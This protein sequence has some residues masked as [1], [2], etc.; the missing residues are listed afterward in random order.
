MYWLVCCEVIQVYCTFFL[1]ILNSVLSLA[2]TRTGSQNWFGRVMQTRN[3]L[4]RLIGPN[5]VKELIKALPFSYPFDVHKPRCMIQEALLGDGNFSYPVT[6]WMKFC[7]M[8][9]RNLKW[10]DKNFLEF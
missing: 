4:C 6:T 1:L 5:L 9:R 8:P 3:F 10:S 2:R 7:E